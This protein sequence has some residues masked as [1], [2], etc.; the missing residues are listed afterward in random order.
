MSTFV[1][2]INSICEIMM[3]LIV[4]GIG[5]MGIFLNGCQHYPYFSLKSLRKEF[6]YNPL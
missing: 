3:K 1:L 5:I 2:I 6:G 4:N